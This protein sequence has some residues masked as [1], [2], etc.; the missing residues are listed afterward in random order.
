M[1]N[2][3]ITNQDTEKKTEEMD[4]SAGAPAGENTDSAENSADDAIKNST[5]YKEM[6]ETVKNAIGDALPDVVKNQL[7]PVVKDMLAEMETERKLL[8][9]K[10]A[11][12]ED[13]KRGF[14][15]DLAHLTQIENG[16]KKPEVLIN[17]PL[18]RVENVAEPANETNEAANLVPKPL[19]REIARIARNYGHMMRDAFSVPMTTLMQDFPTYNQAALLGDFTTNDNDDRP[20]KDRPEFGKITLTIRDWYNL[21][22]ISRNLLADTNTRMY[23]VILAIVAEGYAG[24]MDRE[25]FIGTGTGA[26][27]FVGAMV[28]GNVPSMRAATGATDHSKS[29]TVANMLRLM[30]QVPTSARNNGAFYMHKS[31]WTALR[32]L[33]NASNYI[34]APREAALI[35]A[36]EPQGISPIGYFDT[37]PV[38]ESEY[39]PA[40]STTAA[41]TQKFI[42]FGDLRRGMIR[43][44]REEFSFETS[45]EASYGTAKNTPNR[46]AF[47][48]RELL[49]MSTARYALNVYLPSAMA[50][51][52]NAAS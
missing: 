18:N 48:R 1:E 4:E 45:T 11:V 12:D 43:G 24:R 16:S 6:K 25:G 20:I 44:D 33:Q 50:T 51:L 15:H 49:L 19:Y 41:T 35:Q 46:S 22:P 9:K 8:N 26:S 28:N 2:D 39:L 13:M 17:T 40:Y 3:T 38:Y 42:L 30:D 31:Q 52:A 34:M 23:D 14:I 36:T 29:L 37:K 47:T 32:L 5:E 10:D 7:S 27:P 21:F